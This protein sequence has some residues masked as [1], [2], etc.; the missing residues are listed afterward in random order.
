MF[1][2]FFHIEL[3]DIKVV[4]IFALKS[5]EKNPLKSFV[6]RKVVVPLHT[7]SAGNAYVKRKQNDP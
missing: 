1:K 4:L 6:V 2:N 3:I 7:L 5:S